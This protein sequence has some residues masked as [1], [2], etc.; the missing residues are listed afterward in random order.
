MIN[1]EKNKQ[2]AVAFYKLM[3]NDCR[4]AEAISLEILIYSIIRT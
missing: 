4:P 3:F 1:I 2:T